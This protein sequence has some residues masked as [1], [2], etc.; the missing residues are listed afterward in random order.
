MKNERLICYIARPAPAPDEPRDERRDDRRERSARHEPGGRHER[1]ERIDR[2]N[3]RAWDERNGRR[4]RGDSYDTRY[5]DRYGRGYRPRSRHPRRTREWSSSESRSDGRGDRR[6]RLSAAREGD[7]GSAFARCF[8]L[9]LLG[10]VID[11][12]DGRLVR[13]CDSRGYPACGLVTRDEWL[14]RYT[15]TVDMRRPGSGHLATPPGSRSAEGSGGHAGKTCGSPALPSPRAPGHLAPGV[16]LLLALTLPDWGVPPGSS[17]P[18]PWSKWQGQHGE[19]LDNDVPDDC[20][21]DGGASESESYASVAAGKALRSGGDGESDPRPCPGSGNDAA[22]PVTSPVD[23]AWLAGG[24]LLD[25]IRATGTRDGWTDVEI[26]QA[27]AKVRAASSR[28]EP[29]RWLDHLEEA[30][31]WVAVAPL[32]SPVA[33]AR[34][35]PWAGDLLLARVS[36]VPR[37]ALLA[38]PGSAGVCRALEPSEAPGLPGGSGGLERKREPGEIGGECPAVL[39]PPP[40]MESEECDARPPSPEAGAAERTPRFVKSESP[41]RSS[42]LGGNS[43]ASDY[44]GEEDDGGIYLCPASAIRH[45]IPHLVYSSASGG[46]GCMG[47]YWASASPG[48]GVAMRR[49]VS[50]RRLP[51]R[52][53]TPRR[54]GTGASPFRRLP[55][56]QKPELYSFWWNCAYPQFMDIYINSRRKMVLHNFKFFNSWCAF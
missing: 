15:G 24:D 9:G 34:M 35:L 25:V 31:K 39:T 23:E 53:L 7:G 18:I 30:T 56:T 20:T 1:D 49:C 48:D 10:E 8:G 43:W 26:R 32:P 47:A 41:S 29:P 55:I 13:L 46:N 51:A 40:P 21:S 45:R 44:S 11:V 19:V 16:P 6:R 54:T 4:E 17:V 12:D 50:L 14:R 27:Q 28:K 42:I 22:D 38:G 36:R 3:R 5:S 52:P 2:D 33:E 37:A